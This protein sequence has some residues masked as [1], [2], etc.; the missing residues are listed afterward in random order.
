MRRR[1]FITLVGSAAAWPL[2]ARAQ[3]RDGL[4]KIGF[5][6]LGNP[7]PEPFIRSL[8]AGLRNLDYVEGKDIQFEI[9][10]ANGKPAALAALARELVTVPVDVIV[11]YQTGPATAAK[12]ATKEIPIVLEIADPVRQGFAA[13]L[14]RPGGNITG[15][16][17]GTFEL[18]QKNLELIRE[19]L[20][21]ARRVAILANGSDP[22]HEP[23]LEF[24]TKG[25]SVLD[26]EI[27]SIILNSGD[28]VA[29]RFAE[30]TDR[31]AEALIVQPSLPL[32]IV[33]ALALEHHL[34]TF[35][36]TPA[37]VEAGGL[38][39]YSPDYEALFLRCAAFVDKI[40]KGA[41]PAELPI[42]LATKFILAVN[43]KT[44]KAL[45]IKLP[46]TVMARAEEVIE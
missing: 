33:A 37:L 36:Q 32:P 19:V 43:L 35:A 20:P 31:K 5:L 1:D 40:F 28:E 9:R 18:A 13:S 39:S 38:A 14:S 46:F 44:A 29:L 45:G 3:Q 7:D 11:A 2:A 16:G 15:V 30:I 21:S 23:F 24:A 10:S 12:E 34:P 6:C 22:F 26:F 17:G 4:R 41:K 8:R 27:D 42:E 25:T